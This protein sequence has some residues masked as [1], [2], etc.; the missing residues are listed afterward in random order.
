[1]CGIAG[2]F[3]FG[4]TA[5]SLPVER[6]VAIRDHMAARGPDGAG[7]WV[8]T[9][10]RVG[11]AHRRLSIID[12]SDAAAQ[13]MVGSSG[14]YHMVFNGEIYNYRDLK[15]SLE[16]QGHVFRTDSDTETLLKLFEIEG[17]A[18][19]SRLRGMFALAIWD[20]AEQTLLLARDPYGI[21]PLYFANHKGCVRFASQ[22]RALLVDPELSREISPAGRVGF[23]MMGSIPDPF[24]IYNAVRS[25]PAGASILVT[26][27]GVGDPVFYARLSDAIA[28]AQP[29]DVEDVANCLRESVA[30]HLVADVE[31]GAFLSG[32]VD[33]GAIV[34]L[35]RDCGQNHIRACTLQFEEFHGTSEDEVPRAAQIAAHY[36]VDHYVRMVTSREFE[37]DLPAIFAAM[38]QP[39]IDGI[40]TWFV[41]KACKELG[42]KVAV[43]GLGGDELMC[44]YSTFNTV[45]FTKRYAGPV[46]RIPFASALSKAFLRHVTPSLLHRNPKL[47][48]ILDYSDSWAGAY[49]LQRAVLLPFELDQIMD[50]DIAR[51]GLAELNFLH[52]VGSQL[53]PEPKT[54]AGRICVLESAQ[55]MR[56]QLLRDSDW[57]GMAHSLE[58]RLPL[59][60][61]MLLQQVGGLLSAFTKGNGKQLLANSPSRALPPGIVSHPKTGF[62]IPAARWLAKEPKAAAGRT[63][64]RGSMS[65]VL[66]N[67]LESRSGA[68]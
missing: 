39:S 16:A 36:D 3:A 8:S 22:V 33:S 53:E 61:Y 62:Q 34:G 68:A 1:M 44:G 18:M 50:E 37:D 11:L 41:S 64:S 38:D 54:D 51:S 55:Y 45:P 12:L 60:D 28:S 15:A 52:L 43:S 24:T 25:C 10:Q 19:L 67:Y 46:S 31:V 63:A 35:M 21:K 49:L 2:Y 57:A 23:E 58:I 4:P 13:P 56:N 26:Q 7:L 14:R 17:P 32:G 40:N 6:L 5:K 59:V 42:L 47:A 66:N 65:A 20:D 9:N 30:Y 48:G 27:A 29:R